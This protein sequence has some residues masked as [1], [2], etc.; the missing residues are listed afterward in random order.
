MASSAPSMPLM[1]VKLT[2]NILTPMVPSC[3]YLWIY[4]LLEHVVLLGAY[5]IQ[6][7]S[8]TTRESS[9]DQ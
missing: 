8:A 6:R 9:K 3:K 2:Q 7:S 4:I 5:K 1:I